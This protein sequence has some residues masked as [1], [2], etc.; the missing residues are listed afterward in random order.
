MAAMVWVPRRKRLIYEKSQDIAMNVLG[1]LLV[2]RVGLLGF[3]LFLH[4]D[5]LFFVIVELILQESE[6]L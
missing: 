1:F 6:F 2:P 3:D 5:K 4:V